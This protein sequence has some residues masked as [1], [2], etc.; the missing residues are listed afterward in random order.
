M[1]KTVNRTNKKIEPKLKKSSLPWQQFLFAG[2]ALLI[3][4][5]MILS[6]LK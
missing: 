3:V 1:N 2:F 5:S 4:V 6:T